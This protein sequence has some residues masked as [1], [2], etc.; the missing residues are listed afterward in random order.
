M[1]KK[2]ETPLYETVVLETLDGYGFETLCARIFQK[3][4][5]GTIENLPC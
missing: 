5:Y 3:L 4:N 2:L 1:S